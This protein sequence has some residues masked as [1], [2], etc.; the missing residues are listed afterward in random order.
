MVDK[1]IKDKKTETRRTAGL[2]LL[3]EDEPGTFYHC[4][5][6]SQI[7]IPRPAIPYDTRF[8]A[9]FHKHW[10]N[11][12]DYVC[13]CPYGSKGDLL[14]VR[15]TF[16]A[17]G[18]WN[19]TEEGKW[20]FEDHGTNYLYADN[21]PGDVYTFRHP[22]VRGWY[23]RPAIHMPRHASRL[24]LAVEEIKVEQIQSITEAG[25]I[26]EGV[27]SPF[28]RDIKKPKFI[29]LWTSINGEKSWDDNVWVWVVKF[30]KHI[31]KSA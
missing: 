17:W 27:G 8:Y 29:E 10:T 7:D 24:T 15:E 13:A 6:V 14:W 31:L 3:N 22:E 4:N 20:K 5:E 25:C 16:Y 11:E 12:V 23:K 9:A 21:P 28:T 18:T 30:K 19:K 2:G 1:I 26:A